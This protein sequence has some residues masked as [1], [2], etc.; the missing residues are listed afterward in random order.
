MTLFRFATVGPACLLLLV[1]AT[2]FVA[3]YVSLTL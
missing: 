2:S 1:I 3:L